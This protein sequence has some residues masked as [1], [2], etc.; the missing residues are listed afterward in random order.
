MAS[1]LL[2]GVPEDFSRVEQRMLELAGHDVMVSPP[3]ANAVGESLGPSVLSE[4][5]GHTSYDAIL[6]GI[7]SRSG[8]NEEQQAAL[9][10]S[11]K[12]LYPNSNH[13]IYGVENAERAHPLAQA[14]GI[15]FVITEPRLLM[16]MLNNILPSQG[17]GF[18]L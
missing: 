11:F 8:L 9:I 15:D 12:T 17:Q 14:T 6:F 3:T 1:I 4:V 18:T 13:I 7:S 5:I 2:V 16:P 10:N